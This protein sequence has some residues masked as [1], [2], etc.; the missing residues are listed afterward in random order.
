MASYQSKP[1][2]WT[3]VVLRLIV[4]GVFAYAGYVKLR[5]PW[6]YFAMSI[7]NYHLLSYHLVVLVA[8]TLPATEVAVGLWLMTGIWPRIPATFVSLLLAVFF[9][10]MVHAKMAGQQIDC[11]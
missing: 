11:G 2:F 5:D 1:L 9:A 3:L 4:G 8:R 6:A 10:A 7:D